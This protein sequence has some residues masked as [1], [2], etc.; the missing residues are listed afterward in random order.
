MN[1]QTISVVS[2]CKG[3][4]NNCKFCVSNMHEQNYSFSFDKF[5]YK[6]RLKH[7]MLNNVGTLVLTGTGEILQN[8]RFLEHFADVLE[9][10]DHPFPNVA[11]QTT[12]VMLLNIQNINLL[13]RLGVNTISLSAS[14]IFDDERNWMINGTPQKLR[15]S[16]AEITRKIKNNGWNLR[17]SLNLTYVYDERTP[18]EIVAR[19][20][21]LGADQITFRKLWQDGS[22]SEPATWVRNHAMNEEKFVELE[23][24]VRE[25]GMPL[26]RLPFGFML[27]SVSGMSVAVDD[28]CMSKEH[29]VD[30]TLK[31]VILRENGKL[32]SRWDDEGSLIF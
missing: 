31:Y 17:M 2:P 14:D 20:K 29:E 32:Y 11:V 10:L 30:D 26:F 18:E 3:C 21:E 13:N 25:N 8:T 28:D 1:I 15:I 16:L 9:E 19:C 22:D 12:G 7:A 5:Q 23:K 6:K 27:Y 24:Y 4:V